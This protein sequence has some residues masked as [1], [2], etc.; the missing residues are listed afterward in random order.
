MKTQTFLFILIGLFLAGCASNAKTPTGNAVCDM[1]KGCD[2]LEEN[3]EYV[4][5]P[6]SE[7]SSEMKKYSYDVDG[8]EV[9]YF[10]VKGTDGEIRTAF[11]ACDVC[12]GYKGYR[13]R[14]NDVV[15]NNCG[16]FF[17]ISDIGTKNKG[18]GCWPSYLSNKIEGDQILVKKS[19]L[20]EGVFRFR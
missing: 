8:V 7:I 18:G 1:K 9:N 16:R 6:V 4:K 2:S 11:D 17:S 14:G 10:A 15:C 5:I 20:A 19:E 3:G 13:Q 12:G